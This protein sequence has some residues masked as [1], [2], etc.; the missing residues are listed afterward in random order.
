MLSL[1]GINRLLSTL[2]SSLFV[3]RHC[4]S[5]SSSIDRNDFITM[6]PNRNGKNQKRFNRRLNDDALKCG[7]RQKKSKRIF[8]NFSLALSAFID[9]SEINLHNNW[10]DND[11]TSVDAPRI[12]SLLR[13]ETT[14]LKTSS[15]AAVIVVIAISNRNKSTKT[16]HERERK[17]K[18]MK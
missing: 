6:R 1:H 9:W 4:C 7:K 16:E 12:L 10:A 18:R 8:N 5:L 13:I 14:K 17:N 3:R 11:V 2:P 15:L